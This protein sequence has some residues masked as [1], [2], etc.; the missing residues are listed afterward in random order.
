MFLNPT[1]T[2]LFDELHKT[3]KSYRK[4]YGTKMGRKMRLKLTNL[5]Q[6]M[7]H[8][9]YEDAIVFVETLTLD[10]IQEN[11]DHKLEEML[12]QIEMGY[13]LDHNTG[14]V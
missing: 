2:F 13:Y 4:H 14:R 7:T 1:D 12:G 8:G 3:F 6:I 10:K 5:V 9:R 11:I